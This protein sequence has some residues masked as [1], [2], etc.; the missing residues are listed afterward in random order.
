M[1]LP[2]LAFVFDDYQISTEQ[3]RISF[4]DHSALFALKTAVLDL[5]TGKRT[6][7]K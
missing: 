4:I 1:L 7:N 6:D 3:I 2:Y 5:S